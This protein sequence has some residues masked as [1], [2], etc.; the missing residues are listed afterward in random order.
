[1]FAYFTASIATTFTVQELQGGINGLED[2]PGKRVATVAESPA[3][4]FLDSQTNLLF[5]DYSTL[6]ALY[7]AVED[8][9]EVDAV[10]YDAPVLQYFVTHQGQGRYQV[11]G[12]VFQSLDYGIA[13]QPN[14][15]YRE[16]INAALLRLY[17][18]GQYEEIYQ[19]WFG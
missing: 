2:L 13:L 8:G 16:A 5:R 14:S 19:E 6:E 3:A 17:E 11:V 4:E 15:P 18:T 7:I 1:M 12:D 10:V 9:N